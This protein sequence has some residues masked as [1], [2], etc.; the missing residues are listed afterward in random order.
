MVYNNGFSLEILPSD[1]EIIKFTRGQSKYVGLNNGIEYKLK[2]GN[3]RDTVCDVNIEIE[4]HFI[5]LW[6]I[7][8]HDYTIIEQKLVF[9]SG[10]SMETVE[11]GVSID[12]FMNGLIKAT[13]YPKKTTPRPIL[14]IIPMQAYGLST[15]QKVTRI[16]SLS[17]DDIDRNN[18]KAI[19]IR[20]VARKSYRP[21]QLILPMVNFM[22]WNLNPFSG[23]P[24]YFH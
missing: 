20:L 4:G 3:H 11:T 21:Y 17:N 13:F 9:F 5:G 22:G 12:Q 7:D 15:H 1:T 16:Q 18:I 19:S 23:Y 2:L 10:I 24:P 6:G 14:T 8:P